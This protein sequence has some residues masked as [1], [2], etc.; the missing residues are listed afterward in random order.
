MGPWHVKEFA[1]ARVQNKITH[2][3]N[4][5]GCHDRGCAWHTPS[6]HH[7]TKNPSWWK[8]RFDLEDGRA[9]LP[10]R[11]PWAHLRAF[12]ILT[13]I[14]CRLSVSYT[15][16]S[17]NNGDTDCQSD[18]NGTLP[19]LHCVTS[20][21]PTLNPGPNSSV[22]HTSRVNIVNLACIIRKT[23]FENHWP[24]SRYPYRLMYS[25][26]AKDGT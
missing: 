22:T 9:R 12:C 7:M 24:W 21:S 16:I 10:L 15:W 6:P 2:C 13:A 14:E 17:K 20:V 1:P 3:A 18:W 8:S 4:P 25:T 26:T 23:N 19:P 11:G 5:P